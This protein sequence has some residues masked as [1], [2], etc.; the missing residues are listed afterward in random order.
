MKFEFFIALKNLKN[1][2]AGKKVS[3]PIVKISILSICLAV[4]V[5][6]ITIAVV[7][8]FQHEVS[9]KVL[10]FGSHAFISSSNSTSLFEN[11]AILKEQKFIQEIKNHHFIKNIQAIAYK[12]AIFQTD[13]SK[14]KSQEIQSIIV[15]GVNQDY[16]F[17]FF[18][19]HLVAGKLPQYSELKKSNEILISKKIA[20]DLQYKVG[21]TA[22]TFFVKNQPIRRNFK[23]VGIFETGM[24]D[25]DKK[26]VIAD[27][28]HIQEMS[29]WG[30]QASIT[31]LDTL[32]KDCLVIKAE[33]I[34]GNGNFRFDWGK[35]YSKTGGFICYPDKDTVFR[36]IVSDYW[37]FMD[38]R[39]E[40]TSIPD[41]AYLKMTVSKTTNEKFPIELNEDGTVKKEFLSDD[42]MKFEIFISGRK[43]VFEKIDGLGSYRNYVGAFEINFK[44]WENFDEN[45]YKLKKLINFNHSSAK[46]DLRVTSIKEDQEEIFVWLSFLD[47]NVY[48]IIILM[49][50]IGIINM[51]SAMLVMILIKTPFIGM[52]KA[53]GATNWT[54]RKIFLIQVTYL[55]LRG[56]FW[57]NLVGIG[58]CLLQE[59]FEIIPLNPEVYYLNAVP[60]EL[61]LS[62]ILWVNGLTLVVCLAAMLIPS[63]VISKISPSKSIKFN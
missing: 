42:G 58:L 55:I 41:T 53:M 28:K 47:I 38:G 48:I 50:I 21:D 22:R 54:I 4:L 49:L 20:N 60:I 44:S 7:I 30:I 45:T 25:L 33:A 40:E 59:Y 61:S 26:V 12:P 1:E 57:G 34:G 46:Q 6:L 17:T 23:I 36:V 9:D 8:G 32:I 19:Q 51:G 13:K 56:M 31:V 11:E 14:S 5:N 16:D 29:D 3:R 39:G 15:K 10:G 27:I 18:K 37:M 52:M 62:S 24:E 35:G 43:V 2:V 63:F